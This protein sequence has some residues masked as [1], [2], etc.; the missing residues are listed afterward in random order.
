MDHKSTNV[1]LLQVEVPLNSELPVPTLVC[2]QAPYFKSGIADKVGS[3]LVERGMI[4][5]Y[6]VLGPFK[7]V[8]TKV[9]GLEVGIGITIGTG[10]TSHCVDVGGVD[11]E[12]RNK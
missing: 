8:T 5:K 12:E 2:I 1:Y 10:T 6:E 7:V 11:V 9:E 3:R 4:T